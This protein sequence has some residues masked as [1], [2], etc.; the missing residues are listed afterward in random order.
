MHP[1]CHAGD[2]GAARP[3]VG[4]PKFGETAARDA[5]C[6]LSA[7]PPHEKT[8][9]HGHTFSTTIP[10]ARS[11]PEVHAPAVPSPPSLKCLQRRG[12]RPGGVPGSL[13]TPATPRSDGCG[14]ALIEIGRESHRATVR[15][16]TQTHTTRESHTRRALRRLPARSGRGARRA[17]PRG[18]LECRRGGGGRAAVRGLEQTRRL[19]EATG[20]VACVGGAAGSAL[21]SCCYAAFGGVARSKNRGQWR[22]ARAGGEGGQGEDTRHLLLRRH[23]GGICL[24]QRAGMD[25]RLGRLTGGRVAPVRGRRRRARGQCARPYSRPF[26]E[27]CAV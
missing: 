23:R 8:R 3:Q 20:F 25:P 9:T 11:S 4:K 12:R 1:P 10:P 6:C 13:G 17:A 14:R 24:P 19:G 21:P 27:L 26:E 16:H 18:P 15:P 2:A 5:T 22:A 7:R